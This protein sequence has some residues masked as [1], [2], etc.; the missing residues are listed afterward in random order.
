MG[1]ITVPVHMD[2]PAHTRLAHTHEATQ[3]YAAVSPE[4]QW[5]HAPRE[6]L[7]NLEGQFLA[8]AA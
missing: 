7:C 3:Q 6:D 8:E 1:K 5:E 2:E 4:Y